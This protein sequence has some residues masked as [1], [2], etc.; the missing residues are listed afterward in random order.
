MRHDVRDHV[1]VARRAGARCR[2]AL[3]G[4][5]DLVAI[6]DACRNGDPQLALALHAAVA[7]TRVTWRLHDLARPTAAIAQGDVDYLAE[8]RLAYVA[9]LARPLA[10]GTGDGRSARLSAA[11]VAR[12]AP[13][14]AGELDLLIGPGDRLGEGQPKVIAQVRPGGRA[15]PP[16]TTRGTAEERVEQV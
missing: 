8:H 9:Q 11:A 14:K 4:Q 1:Q 13:R 15:R 10:L 3:P 5:P 7:T 6:V 16:S 12:L 2:L